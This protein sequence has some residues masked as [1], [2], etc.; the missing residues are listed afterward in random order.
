M[1]FV[2][3]PDEF[4]GK[5]LPLESKH[6]HETQLPHTPPNGGGGDVSSLDSM[7]HE[8]SDVTPLQSNRASKI[9]PRRL[10]ALRNLNFE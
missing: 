10:L 1:E 2:F 5:I 6:A 3:Q 7:S 9:P 8:V 4:G